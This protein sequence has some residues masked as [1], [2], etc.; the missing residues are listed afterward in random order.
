MS[1]AKLRDL[2]RRW[3][4]TGTCEDEAAYST[5]RVRVG[6]L[7]RERLELAAYCGH[8]GARSASGVAPE[9][10]FRRLLLKIAAT[11]GR[12]A[13]ARVCLGLAR[14]L[15]CAHPVAHAVLAAVEAGA[16]SDLDT[17]EVR[18]TCESAMEECFAQWEREPWALRDSGLQVIGNLG[19]LITNDDVVA[20]TRNFLKILFGGLGRETKPKR[21]LEGLQLH[22]AIW[23]LARD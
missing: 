22:G 3:K 17:T 23:A 12:P 9:P 6:D 13:C 8:E 10:S 21:T 11:G 20:A 18:Q 19:F 4:E 14:S 16:R 2:E 7:T 1:D 5:E 15:D